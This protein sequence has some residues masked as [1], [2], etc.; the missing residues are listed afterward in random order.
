MM[1]DGKLDELLNASF[2]AVEDNGFSRRLAMAIAVRERNA[3][4]M[5]WGIVACACALLMA[6]APVGD[7]A[8]LFAGASV[9]LSRSVPFAAGCAA[10]ALTQTAMRILAD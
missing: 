3:E 9:D 10:L 7:F 8:R 2:P 1:D 6:V 5:E 4:W